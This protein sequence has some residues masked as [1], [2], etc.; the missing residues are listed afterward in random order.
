MVFSLESVCW[1]LTRWHTYR[2]HG[3][4]GRSRSPNESYKGGDV[5]G[6]IR[7]PAGSIGWLLLYAGVWNELI[8]P[9]S[10]HQMCVRGRWTTYA[11][12]LLSQ[13]VSLFVSLVKSPVCPHSH[14]PLPFSLPAFRDAN[15]LTFLPFIFFCFSF[16]YVSVGFVFF[17]IFFMII[18][19][20]HTDNI[21]EIIFS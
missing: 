19:L 14:S 20:Y 7:W 5:R 11:L 6:G 4:R 10:I 18:L 1:W 15:R 12:A 8:R 17:S 16:F 21:R 2:T 13:T 9:E 3:G